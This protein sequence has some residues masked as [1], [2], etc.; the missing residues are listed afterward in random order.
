MRRSA[1]WIVLACSLLACGCAAVILGA[2]AG[3]GAAVYLKGKVTQTYAAEYGPSVRACLEALDSLEMP[4]TEK[5][6]GESQ[7]SISARRG[8]GTPVSVE[9]VRAGPT[10]TEVSVRTG[11]FGITEIEASE[12][13]QDRIASRLAAMAAGGSRPAAGPGPG[14]APE[15]LESPPAPKRSPP[16]AARKAAG[17][18]GGPP[19]KGRPPGV[20]LYFDADSNE[21]RPEEIAKLNA[22]IALHR[23]RP[24]LKLTLDGYP[25][26]SGPS[27]YNRIL[28][29]SRAS[30]VKMYLVGK[31]IDPDR[32]GISGHGARSLPARSAD[33]QERR[34]ERCVEV[35]IEGE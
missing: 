32:I 14:P 27:D 10:R 18:P 5:T 2:G 30:T 35:H 19:A 9:V 24:E 17:A 6:A 20:V 7:T 8:D 11:A 34:P 26:S 3:T 22:F 21:L 33:G 28:S 16:A 13:I 31:G 25:D 23:N 12:K 1:V 29:E 4:V 15:V